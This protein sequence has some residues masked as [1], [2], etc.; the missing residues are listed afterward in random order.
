MSPLPKITHFPRKRTKQTV[1]NKPVKPP[2][3]RNRQLTKLI[4]LWP[5]ELE[6]CT[7]AACLHIIALLEK[8]LRG[9]RQRGQG[10]HWSYDLNR[11]AAL[12]E[13]LREERARLQVLRRLPP[14]AHRS[15][16][17]PNSK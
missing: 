9:E 12:V 4:G 17:K 3:D 15:H 5:R 7:E 10:G 16:K 13:A 11:H 8:A 6:D 1:I 14:I 2:Y